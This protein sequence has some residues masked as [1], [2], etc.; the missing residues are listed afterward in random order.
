MKKSNTASKP[1][2][3][4]CGVASVSSVV[5]RNSETGFTILTAR[6][7]RGIITIVCTIPFALSEGEE[8]EYSGEQVNHPRYGEQIKAEYVAVKDPSTSDGIKAYL[9]SGVIAGIGPATAARIVG[10][11]GDQTLA[12]LDD[13]PTKLLNIRGIGR[14]TLVKISE[15]WQKKREG[16]KI[17][18]ELCKLG[19]SYAY[20]VRVYKRF[21]QHAVRVTRD[22]PYVLADEVSGIGFKI[23]DALARKLGFA[24]DHPFRIRSG[25]LYTLSQAASGG[26]SFLPLQE[27]TEEAAAILDVLPDQAAAAIEDL[28]ALGQIIHSRI[29]SPHYE[30]A[31]DIYYS[32][33]AYKAERYI[34]KRLRQLASVPPKIYSLKL[35]KALTE[36][37]AEAAEAALTRSLTVITG[38]AGTGKSYTLSAITREL[39]RL[40][41]SYCLCAPTG[42]AS[43]RMTELTGREAKTIHRMIGAASQGGRPMF[44]DENPLDVQYVLCDESSMIDIFLMA[45]LLRALPWNGHI[46]F[47]GDPYQLPPVGVG[48]PF[49]SLIG[50][51]ICPV[52]R[53]SLIKRQQQ[54]SDVIS[55]ANQI[56]GG[57]SPVWSN[58]R[59]A[60]FFIIHDPQRVAEKVVELAT[61]RVPAK[62]GISVRDIQVLSPM[63]KGVIGT[64]ALNQ[65]IQAVLC[66]DGSV[67]M[68]PFRIGDKVMQVANDYNRGVAG[69]F[70]GDMGYV[71]HIDTEEQCLFVTFE[72]SGEVVQYDAS[73]IGSLRHAFAVTVHKYMGSE[74]RAVI[75][76]LHD[77][78]QRIMLRR[79]LIYTAVTR[80]RQT[81]IIVGTRRAFDM[82]VANDTTQ[83]RYT[84]LF[85]V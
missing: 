70:N 59:D 55:I 41:I 58:D 75:I 24:T 35:D 39:E 23:A 83:K 29:S 79:D 60:Y 56:K 7:D 63:R 31:T 3:N 57:K 81:L 66:P 43:K 73:D 45:D 9:A 8:I 22:N 65:M 37:Q 46:L 49:F 6:Q 51:G 82:A 33:A 64:E 32:Q 48:Q 10:V 14:K 13:D 11:F 16:A 28:V 40:E 85:V 68:G 27:L 36:E 12:V 77:G 19:L 42:K 18:A 5:F 34:E 53:L 1:S 69:I 25:I 62:F 71:T 84:G 21:E 44:N 67:F 74:A 2:T 26:H 47:M 72:G 50:S 80:T 20:G 38:A 76:P 61:Q 4:I 30:G 15:S 17:V 52:M 78:Q 54:D